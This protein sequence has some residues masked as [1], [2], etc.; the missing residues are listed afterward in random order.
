MCPHITIPHSVTLYHCSRRDRQPSPCPAVLGYG[1]EEPRADFSG[2]HSTQG[3]LW[4][5]IKDSTTDRQSLGGVPW[6]NQD[7]AGGMHLPATRT[8]HV[9]A[10]SGE[11]HSA[12]TCEPFSK[13]GTADSHYAA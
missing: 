12:Q 6:A 11:A 3:P 4:T 7:P 5:D 13:K 9:R 1:V 10:A 8:A 2:D